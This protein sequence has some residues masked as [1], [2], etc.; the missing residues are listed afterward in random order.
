[1]DLPHV[2]G[3]RI[4]NKDRITITH[5]TQTSPGFHLGIIRSPGVVAQKIENVL[6]LTTSLLL[7]SPHMSQQFEMIANLRGAEPRIWRQLIVAGDLTLVA[8]HHIL[9]IVFQWEDAHLWEFRL[10]GERYSL[11]D[12][13]GQNDTRS[14]T[15]SIE[16]AVGRSKQGEYAYDFGD[17]WIV[18]LTINKVRA[19]EVLFA[20]VKSGEMRGPLEDV[21]GVWGHNEL[22][23]SL[24]SGTPLDPERKKWLPHKYDPKNFD[25]D[26]LNERLDHVAGAFDEEADGFEEDDDDDDDGEWDSDD[27]DDL[28]EPAYISGF[29]LDEPGEPV[30]YDPN[31]SRGPDPERWARLTV[32]EKMASI[33]AYYGQSSHGE[34]VVDLHA[35]L[36][37]HIETALLNGS[38]T[39]G[40]DLLKRLKQRGWARHEALHL[41]IE[42][43]ARTMSAEQGRPDEMLLPALQVYTKKITL[44]AAESWRHDGSLPAYP[45]RKKG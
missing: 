17:D 13:F 2:N 5:L 24:L 14:A 18:D 37:C 1:M 15:T 19:P 12:S 39:S 45:A 32:N 31:D 16:F 21:G 35:L 8:L 9:Q 30:L 29:P 20:Q 38:F 10:L 7:E 11:D 23:A 22:M 42:V 40:Q 43:L 3:R 26:A 41:L 44:K 25:V 28:F 34:D 6:L 36:H 4:V 33:S 27:E